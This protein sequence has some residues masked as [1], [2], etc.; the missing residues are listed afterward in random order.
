MASISR[1]VKVWVTNVETALN[2][3]VERARIVTALEELNLTVTLLAE[4]SIDLVKL[5]G[6]LMVHSVTAKRALWLRHWVADS[7]SKQAL[8]NIPFNGKMLFGKTLEEAIKRVTGGKTGLLPQRIRKRQPSFR[9]GQ[10]EFRR[11]REARSYRPGREYTR[12]QWRGTQSSFLRG[13]KSRAAQT[14]KKAEKS[15]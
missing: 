7:A 14:A 13:V 10:T 12:G 6:R 15:F 4:A 5:L 11:A 1:A 9:P 8:C 2:S 3:G